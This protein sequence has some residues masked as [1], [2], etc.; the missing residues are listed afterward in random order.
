[1]AKLEIRMAEEGKVFGAGETIAGNVAWE[2]G[3]GVEAMDVQLR[4]ATRGKG[5]VDGRVA[6][7]VRFEKLEASGQRPFEFRCPAEPISFSGK[8]ISLIWSV[9]VVVMPGGLE[10]EQ[11]IT[12]S[13]T[14]RAVDLYGIR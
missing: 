10:A 4:W 13:P 14:G 6:E 11:A 12:V 5:D 3:E 1:M 2:V 8:L 7:H 9:R